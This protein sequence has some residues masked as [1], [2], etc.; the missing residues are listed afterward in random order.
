MN[1]FYQLL[2]FFQTLLTWWFIVEPWEQAVR[3]R[4]GKHLRLF[5]AGAHFRVP[6][7]DH[8]YV[9]NVRRRVMGL[10]MH[11]L[12]T[13]DGQTLTVSG[14]LGY[15]ITDV[16][17]LHQTLND[18]EGTV[19][20]QVQGTLARYVATHDAA[21]CTPAQLMEEV[22]GMLPLEQ[23]GLGEA[24]FFLQGYVAKIPAFRLIQE[25]L[26][27][28]ATGGTLSTGGGNQAGMAAP[29]WR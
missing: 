13:R 26:G 12:T 24:D 4:F 7:F 5:E 19:A 16:L 18:A 3:V 10:G 25:G 6:Y 1:I 17:K 2:Q 23:Y 9:Q 8:I 21:E 28:W 11:T 14:S 15:K 27:G 20:Q 29:G 22:N